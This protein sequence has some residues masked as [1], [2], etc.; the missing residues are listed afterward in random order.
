MQLQGIVQKC[1]LKKRKCFRNFL[2]LSV[3]TIIKVMLLYPP[4]YIT[5][6]NLKKLQSSFPK[7]KET[8]LVRLYVYQ[9]L[10]TLLK[11]YFLIILLLLQEKS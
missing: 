6:N 7:V 9:P 3:Y 4:T 11:M 8:P 2:L 1:L 5:F 10:I